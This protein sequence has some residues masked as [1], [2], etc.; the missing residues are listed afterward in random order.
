[1][2]DRI[3]WLGHASFR[4]NG[5]PHTDG[6]VV[7]IDPWRVPDGS[8]EADLILVSHD[9]HD[10]CSPADIARIRTPDTD[11]LA[12]QRAAD[13]I[14]PGV[15]VLRPWQ[16]AVDVFGV[17]V[18]AVPAY[19][20]TSAYHERSYGGL[21][22]VITLMRHDIYFAGDTDLIP[23]METI[24]C[25]IALLPVGGAYTMSYEEAVKAVGLLNPIIAIPMH[26]GREVPGSRGYGRSFVQLLNGNVQAVELPVENEPIHA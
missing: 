12:N 13:L 23:E 7:Y 4:I 25:D 9:H 19:T 1:M 21:G 6:P 16:A 24:G 15:R 11:I 14:G 26:Y 17:S 2:L 10:H 18:R 3:H 5:P 22:F 20:L 8:P